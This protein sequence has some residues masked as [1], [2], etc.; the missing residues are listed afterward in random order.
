MAAQTNDG[1]LR[2]AVT[3]VRKALA[4]KLDQ[5]DEV[6]TGPEDMTGKKT[7]TVIRRLFG[8][9]R[10]A[11]RAVPDKGRQVIQWSGDR[12]EVTQWRA[13]TSGPVEVLLAP[14]LVQQAIVFH[15]QWQAVG[16]VFAEPGVNRRRIAATEHQI[17]APA[18][19]VLQQRIFFGQTH[20]VVGAD[21]GRRCGKDDA[22]GLRCNISQQRGGRG[23]D[24]RR[25]VVLTRGEYVQTD[26]FGF[27]RDLQGG[28]NALRFTWGTGVGRVLC[29]VANGVDPELH[30]ASLPWV[31][32]CLKP[33][34]RR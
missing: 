28:L 32:V 31:K 34:S 9:F 13:E 10:C 25:V 16:D 18:A 3:V 30:K 8:D 21:Q 19:E 33:L 24:E 14:Q 6:L 22:L 12:G 26:V 29:D 7:V 27:L 23:C 2:R 15:R 1:L 17:H 4:V 5:G 20:R 11:N